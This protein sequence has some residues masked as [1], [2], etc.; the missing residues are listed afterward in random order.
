MSFNAATNILTVT[1][2]PTDFGTYTLDFSVKTVFDGM[3]PSQNYT[4]TK[5]L[6]IYKL[7][8]GSGTIL[9]QTYFISTPSLTLALP[10]IVTNPAGVPT[11]ITW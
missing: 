5:V 7:N 2:G 9:D 3:A 6:K 11:N 8:I 1:P 4:L 10:T